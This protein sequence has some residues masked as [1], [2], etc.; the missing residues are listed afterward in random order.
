MYKRHLA[1]D[2]S[3]VLEGRWWKCPPGFDLCDT[4]LGETIGSMCILYD[5]GDVSPILLA[6]PISAGGRRVACPADA[7]KDVRRRFDNPSLGRGDEDYVL[8]DD[9][10]TA[11]PLPRTVACLCYGAF[12]GVPISSSS[13]PTPH[14]G[15]WRDLTPQITSRVRSL[16]RARDDG[17]R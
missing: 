2:T 14:A 8:T 15:A 16:D 11:S 9:C 4:V 17:Q 1:D 10:A 12:P 5:A 3:I 13:R 7:R 6:F